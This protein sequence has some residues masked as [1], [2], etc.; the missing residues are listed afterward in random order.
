MATRGLEYWLLLRDGNFT[1]GMEKA[2]QKTMGLDGAL[3][4]VLR[5]TIALGGGAMALAGIRQ[6][7]MEAI[8]TTAKFEGYYNV[9][10]FASKDMGEFAKNQQFLNDTI[11]DMKLPLQESYEGY[12]KLLSAMKN[13]PLESQ[14]RNI[15]KGVMTAST[16]LHLD[17][18]RQGL[19]MFALQQMV[20][21]GTVSSEEL[22]RQLGESLPG[23]MN[24]AADAMGM[25]LEKFN[26]ALEKGDI[27]AID[28]LPKFAEKLQEHF[29]KSLPEAINS[30]QAKL[31]EAQNKKLELKQELGVTIGPEY[32]RYLEL[33][34]SA[35]SSLQQIVIWSR[36]NKAILVSMVAIG[37]TYLTLQVSILTYKRLHRALD[38]QMLTLGW[39][40]LRREYAIEAVQ[41]AQLLNLGRMRSLMAG[42]KAAGML[43]SPSGWIAAG[44]TAGVGAL[45]YL[46]SKWKETQTKMAEDLKKPLSW[47]EYFKFSGLDP[48]LRQLN[49]DLKQTIGQG[50]AGKVGVALSDNTMPDQRMTAGQM[51]A[52]QLQQDRI[53]KFKDMV[54]KANSTKELQNLFS[55]PF[56]ITKDNIQDVLKQ[57]N[58]RFGDVTWKD[59]KMTKKPI[60]GLAQFGFKKEKDGSISELKTGALNQGGQTVSESVGAGRQVRNV[61]VTINGGLVGELN[62]STTHLQESADQIERKMK[63]ILMRAIRD[64]EIA[65]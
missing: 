46:Y 44:I 17:S 63:E 34:N 5:S 32:L 24:L 54:K 61:T 45:T 31:T 55:V 19:V 36:E 59:G 35:L 15:F 30:M 2:K 6:Y 38:K 23:A 57:I 20:S 4:K 50:K 56:S 29:G 28:F 8:Q 39:L 58:D 60:V 53:Q 21:K 52:F 42:I 48:S 65:L 16:V 11:R 43:M 62:V 47:G 12:S 14:A 7:G 18:Y 41:K 22:K 25:S 64:S 51:T 9:L 37:G 1:S 49:I 26:K 33:Q 13:T 10:K 27:Q 40:R 3:N